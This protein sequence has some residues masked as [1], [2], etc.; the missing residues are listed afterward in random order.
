MGQVATSMVPTEQGEHQLADSL[1]DKRLVLACFIAAIA[2]L[3]FAMLAGWFFSFQFLQI[4][5]FPDNEY[6]S[7]GRWRMVHTNVVLYGFLANAYLGALHWCTPRLSLRPVLSRKL[8]WF[9]FVAWQTMTV[10]T[11]L[12]LLGGHAQAVEWGEAPPVIDVG[13]LVV[14]VL[15]AINFS[16]PILRM[17][18]PMYAT[19]WYFL[20][21]FAWV[22]PLYLTGN[23]VPQYVAG[24]GTGAIT[25]LVFY[26]SVQLGV[27]PIACGLIYYFVPVL[28]GR[29][30]WSH[31]LAMAGFLCLMIVAPWGGLF[32]FAHGSV[33]PT[34]HTIT[35][36]GMLGN[37]AVAAMLII[38]YVASTGG[39]ARSNGRTSVAR[40]WFAAGMFC[41]LIV[42]IQGALLGSS[43]FQD[44]VRFS[45]WVV[46]HSHL[47]MFGAL[48]FWML[49][50]MTHL[51]PSLLGA[52]CWWSD[53]LN[54]WHFWLS[55]A[56]LLIMISALMIAGWR[57]GSMWGEPIPWASTVIAVVSFWALRTVAGLVIIVAQLFFVWNILMTAVDQLSR[58]EE[59]H[60]S[61]TNHP[62]PQSS[63]VQ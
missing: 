42:C 37:A 23:L 59:P 53:R 44:V 52:R 38:N 28:V 60:Q 57:Q 43:A 48:G 34:L 13:N 25:K 54:A 20:I 55:C 56:G 1:V 50:I 46:G 47:V 61:N 31:R 30:I 62:E 19:L 8:S 26:E 36:V 12:A 6:L 51:L 33:S 14:L 32:E 2:Y 7:P 16:I 15:V 22:V 21:G 35:M 4:N 63:Y 49:G 5:A 24:D 41:Y 27:M 3:F 45:D 9:V 58:D 29:P 39:A 17:R 18:G 11:I 40:R 10:A